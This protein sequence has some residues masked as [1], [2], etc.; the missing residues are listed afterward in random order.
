MSRGR[1][2]STGSSVP[3]PGF[4]PQLPPSSILRSFGERERLSPPAE[5]NAPIQMENQRGRVVDEARS[6]ASFINDMDQSVL[7]D[8]M[9][10]ILTEPETDMD[11]PRHVARDSVVQSEDVPELANLGSDT[12]SEN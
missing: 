11:S 12:I 5:L 2:N 9:D 3:V 1:M 4:S 7:G 6:E 8:Q 10:T